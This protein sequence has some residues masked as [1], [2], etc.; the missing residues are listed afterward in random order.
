MA[1]KIKYSFLLLILVTLTVNS[2][3]K[4]QSLSP[5]YPDSL[6]VN[7]PFPR[8][9]IDLNKGWKVFID[10]DEKNFKKINIPFLVEN[11]ESFTIENQF[12]LSV[13]EINNSKF[14]LFSGGVNN[15][16][17]IYLNGSNIFK[18][19]VGE[20][21]FELELPN[22]LLNPNSPNKIIIKIN[23]RIDSKK[24][25]PLKQS[26]LFPQQ[27]KG[28]LRSILII[29]LP[30]THLSG[31][32]LT[33][34]ID[35]KLAVA[36]TSVNFSIENFN[37]NKELTPND[38][39]T[40]NIKLI[41][42]NFV[43]TSYSYDFPIT[44]FNQKEIK[45]S[46]KVEITNPVLW[47]NETPNIYKA[48]LSLL[49]NKQVI[50]KEIKDVSFFRLESL[51]QLLKINNNPFIMKGIT[52]IV[53]EDQLIQNG[54]IDKLKKDFLF[55]KNAG[56]N[57]IRFAKAYPNPLAIKL[58]N[59]IGLFS[60]VELPLNSVPEEFLIDNEFR[61]RAA[62]RFNE[63]T[64]SYS[65]YSSTI[66]WGVGSS[67]L[68]NSTVTEDF[69][70]HILSNK[71]KNNLITYASFIGF[72]KTSPEGLDL[73]GIEIYSMKPEIFSDSIE[74]LFDNENQNLYFLS[75]VNYPNYV[76]NSGGYLIKNSSE[77]KA[78]YFEQILEI[79]KK[80]K[81]NGFF[82]NTLFNY[83]GEFYSL[84][85]G[86][87]NK[88]K[89]GIFQNNLTS[90][91][92]VYKV[93]DSYI[94][95][96]GKVTIPIGNTKDENKITFILIALGLAIL[97][98][99][100]INTSRKFRDDCTR[101][102][103]RPYNFFSDI[104][105]QRIISGFHTF[106]LLLV[107]SGSIS[108]FFTILFYYLRTNILLEKILLSFGEPLILQSFSFLS[109]NPEKGFIII[110]SVL[111]LKIILLTFIIK[112]ASF[113]IKT[114]IQLSSI[115]F[116]IIWALLPFTILL[117]VELILYKILASGNFNTFILVF[118]LL[119]W[120]WILQRIFKGIHVLFEVSKLKVY[121]YGFLAILFLI[122]GISIYYQ[123]TNYTLYY[124]NNTFKQYQLISL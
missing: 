112:A 110:F 19:T 62:N 71:N 120:L 123:I 119:F 80:S 114:K 113:F 43:G 26:F 2:Q 1:R 81:L 84:Y 64:E 90:N 5:I 116:M 25:I 72:Q 21:P 86:N 59:E 63:M 41:P 85:G 4:V 105:D 8:K 3:P 45:Q 102:F 6:I 33:Y 20:I 101:A 77:S 28:I 68:S 57:S 22:D 49:I 124:I 99:I 56:F 65:K 16:V 58:C 69:I 104:R 60:L 115:F 121:F 74:K 76:G 13:D 92:L 38:I 88:Y 98:A 18:K 10:Q 103:F 97:M 111:I 46:F 91:N 24:T 15:S 53:N 54:Y 9:I 48:E 83:E 61:I 23:N 96:K 55:I 89:L 50:D 73:L 87:S 75:E 31:F 36:S 95:E 94:N 35:S 82:I 70:S 100:L 12:S 93:I 39:V 47:S 118:I 27:T 37:L 44:Q 52:Y 67:Y 40:V 66:F 108:L 14:M 32:D 7:A 109:W 29:V 42:K 107:E 30:K 78:K 11:E 51:G 17:D 106:V 117:P 79:S 122:I 34:S